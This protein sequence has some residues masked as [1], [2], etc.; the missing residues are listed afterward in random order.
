MKPL[1][2]FS[3]PRSGSTVVQALLATH[4]AIA[5]SSEPW[6]LLPLIYSTESSG[7]HSI[8]R[9]RLA[10]QGIEDFSKLLPTGLDTY[11]AEIAEMARRLYREAAPEQAEYFLDKTPRY[12]L[13]AD[14]I[15]DM[16]PEAPSLVLWRNPL[17]VVA[18]L[19]ETFGEGRFNLHHYRVDWETALLNLIDVVRSRPERFLILRYEDVVVDPVS[20]L[21][22][23]FSQ[24]RLDPSLA[25]LDEYSSI[26]LQGRLGDKAGITRYDKLSTE[27]LDKWRRT[28]GT[29]VRKAWA[30]RYLKRLGPER[31]EFM[32]YDYP[33][34]A[35][36][37]R[38][39]PARLNQGVSDLTRIAYGG[40]HW[41]LNQLLLEH[42]LTESLRRL[43]LGRG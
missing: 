33:S 43:V 19:I 39:L 27:S 9:H 15:L 16:F 26:P 34:L 20:T 11:K 3:L 6:L 32:G 10:V 2:L 23:V 38:E 14:Q 36:E 37:V 40:V 22:P 13:V 17:A 12:A 42:R 41:R 8:Y 5:T 25:T 18:S 29:V 28:L 31:L 21:L 30:A 24:L 7:V 1:F 4:P 35:D